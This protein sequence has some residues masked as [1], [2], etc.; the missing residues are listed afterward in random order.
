MDD[1]SSL[2]HS[3]GKTKARARRA[4]GSTFDGGESAPLQ[5]VGVLVE[6]PRL[7][8]EMGVDPEPLLAR[9]GEARAALSDI[10]GRLPF[11]VASKLLRTCVE[12]TGRD[13]FSLVVGASARLDHLG[14]IGKLLST[15]ADFG[16]ALVEFVANHPRY[17]RG[18]S[19]Y[20]ID[21]RDS[22]TLIGHRVHH[23]GLRGSVVFSAAATAFG[24]KVFGEL[25][26]VEPTRVLLSLPPPNDLAPYRRAFGRA[27]LVFESEHFGL[28]YNRAALAKP[29][30]TADAALHAES[31]R[32]VAERWNF[33]QPDILDRVMRVL[34]PM[35]LSGTPSL[36]TTAELLVMHPRT[37]NRALQA[38]DL[39]F[40]DLVKEARFEIAA[41][42][43]RESGVS[44]QSL[45]QILGYSEV[46]AFTRFFTSMAGEPPSEWKQ[47][48]LAKAN[49]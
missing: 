35:V 23:P 38:R 25:C 17:V 49:A 43:L 47:R 8:R 2:P 18:A 29:I 3:L 28:V 42:L 13:D 48:E 10:D 37:L 26:G 20:L 14:I 5:R 16:A 31:R 44:V 30:P 24:R 46:S 4:G 32:F 39:S 27:K 9:L 34:V 22:E 41:Q 21:G 36:T 6:I 19:T 45:A 7:L 33:L 12:A 1:R 15:A 11:P 40:R